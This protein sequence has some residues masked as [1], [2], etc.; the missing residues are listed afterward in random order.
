MGLTLSSVS[1]SNFFNFTRRCKMSG[2]MKEAKIKFLLN[3]GR[4]HDAMEIA[5]Y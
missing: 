5:I 2:L 3:S 1:R 4:H